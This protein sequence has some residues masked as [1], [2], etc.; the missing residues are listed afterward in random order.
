MTIHQSNFDVAPSEWRATGREIKVVTRA[1]EDIALLE[2]RPAATS[3]AMKI[4]LA[5][6]AESAP[7]QPSLAL[8]LVTAM[9]K[10]EI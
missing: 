6:K 7:P 8:R 1:A 9:K 10:N 3:L 5:L 2:R 4:I